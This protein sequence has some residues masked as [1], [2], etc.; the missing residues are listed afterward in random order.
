MSTLIKTTDKGL[1]KDHFVQIIVR[2]ILATVNP[3]CFNKELLILGS[4]DMKRSK[5]MKYAKIK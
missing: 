1:Q 2:S 5:I 3:N 4:Y